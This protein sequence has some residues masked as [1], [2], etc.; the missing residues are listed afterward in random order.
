MMAWSYTR[1]SLGIG[2]VASV[3]HC[4]AQNSTAWDDIARCLQ[5]CAPFSAGPNIYI[6][7]ESAM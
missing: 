2:F 6:C 4:Q 7:V 3:I 1:A 5:G